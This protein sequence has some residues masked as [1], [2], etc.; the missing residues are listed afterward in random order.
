MGTCT[1]RNFWRKRTR[2][3]PPGTACD[4]E[5]RRTPLDR[6]T[7]PDRSRYKPSG[8]EYTWV[9]ITVDLSDPYWSRDV[10]N[11]HRQ[12]YSV[13]RARTTSTRTTTM[14]VRTHDTTEHNAGTL[15]H[16]RRRRTP[17]SEASPPIGAHRRPRS[18]A[19]GRHTTGTSIF[20]S[21]FSCYYFPLVSATRTLPE[22]TARTAVRRLGRFDAIRAFPMMIL[23]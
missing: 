8:T 14:P 7:V 1:H 6:R 5:S 12:Y 17:N 13:I 18:A 10:Q 3:R 2:R 20:A 9:R 23:I 16:R 19:R 4:G 22:G 21:G 15:V 11:A